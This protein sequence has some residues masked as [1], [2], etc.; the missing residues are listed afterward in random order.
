MTEKE[1]LFD[2]LVEKSGK[3]KDELQNLLSEKVN[4]LSGLVS[5]E[6]AMYII[7]NELGVRLDNEKPKKQA[8]TAKISQ[9]TEPKTPTSLLCKVLR[10]YDQVTFS[11]SSGGEGSVQ[12]VL[13]GDDTGIIRI[14]FWNDKTDLLANVQDNDVLRVTNAYTRENNHTQRIEVHFG[15]YSD[16]E[17]N[18]EGEDVEVVEY[19]PTIE[20]TDKKITDLTQNDRNVKVKATVT[21]FDIPRFYLACPECFKKVFQDEDQY[22]CAE[23][24]NV[25]AIKVPIVNVIVD[26]GSGTL[27]AVAFRDR[28]EKL[29][30]L[31]SDEIIELTEDIDKYKQFKDS[32]IES[33]VEV[34][35]NSSMNN[36]T[37]ETQLIINQILNIETTT[38][39][40][41]AKELAQ[42]DT[43]EKQESQQNQSQEEQTQKKEDEEKKQKTSTS[44]DDVDID[45][46][47]I[48]IDD[49]L[50]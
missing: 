16:L 24:G 37:E 3:S 15:P 20:F 8:E 10:K 27:N 29:T 36:M 14:V 41:E 7:A 6:G 11:T 22:K 28:A 32:M 45:V 4:E 38:V 17:V 18:P 44:Q 12:S 46:E 40:E 43:Q 9:I 39:E 50:L 35:G 30:G 49:D 26:D 2:M 31:S 42:E 33:T 1:K 23:H 5:E 47:E 25:E 48:S 34:G 19:R 13:V 21:D